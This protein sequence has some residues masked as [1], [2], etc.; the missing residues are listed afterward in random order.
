MMLTESKLEKLRIAA[1]ASGG[2]PGKL[3]AYAAAKRE[4]EALID[5]LFD[6]DTPYVQSPSEQY[7]NHLARAAESGQEVD[8][9]RY[10]LIKE[11]RANMDARINGDDVRSYKGNVHQLREVLRKGDKI[12]AAHVQAAAE[13]AVQNG[14]IDNHVLYATLKR[15]LEQQAAEGDR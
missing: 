10:E 11:R 12:T 1:K 4:F 13:A 5:A 3:A 14:S 6:E 7:L 9:A 2:H 8:I 15:Q